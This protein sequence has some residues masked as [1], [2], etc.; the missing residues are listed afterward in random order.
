MFIFSPLLYS[1]PVI[2]SAGSLL[3]AWN[4]GVLR[5]P[6]LAFAWFLMATLVQT[7]GPLF[8]LPWVVGLILQLALAFYLVA[9]LVRT[10]D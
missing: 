9:K 3:M 6:L 5:R 8:S 4:F 10:N 1:V 2:A 7:S